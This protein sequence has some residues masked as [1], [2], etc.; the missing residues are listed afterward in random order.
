MIGW[1]VAIITG[2]AAVLAGY[3]WR[4]RLIAKLQK[5]L[6]Y[7]LP[8]FLLMN[9]RQII[10]GLIADPAVQKAV[11]EEAA[12]ADQP[13]STIE[14]R[15]IRY[16]KEIAPRFSVF[17]YF[18]IGYVLS[19]FLLK[20]HYAE[21]RA[22]FA[23]DL[24]SRL[25]PNATVV[26]VPNHRSNM[27]VLLLLYLASRTSVVIGGAGEWSRLWP[28]KALVHLAGGYVVD[29]RTGDALYRKVLARFIAQLTAAGVNQ[30]VFP[31]GGL[32]RDARPKESKLG[33]LHYVASAYSDSAERDIVFVPVGINY[34]R[35]PEDLRLV[36]DG[37]TAFSEH[38]KLFLVRA[39]VVYLREVCT[40][41]LN[42]GGYRYGLACADYG[43]PVSWQ[44]WVSWCGYDPGQLDAASHRRCLEELGRSL[45]ER[46]E[47]LIPVTPLTLLAR[48]CLDAPEHLASQKQLTDAF[49]VAA[50]TL[51]DKGQT[52]MF[53]AEEQ[54]KCLTGA[55]AIF[56]RLGVLVA[57][58]SGWK[59]A[60]PLSPLLK[61][62]ANA[63]SHL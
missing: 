15:A 53:S 2:G 4:R 37:G 36:R 42:R 59:V 30:L 54:P 11:A 47:E 1:L 7:G 32:S 9:R 51:R 3:L 20:L 6:P 13:V 61:Y 49:A 21:C 29:R 10:A 46:I 40:L 26:L 14:R 57:D 8:E 17:F 52:L 60:Q 5:E 50:A 25:D 12:S 28:F 39:T 34:D 58:D 55:I 43:H 22:R 41:I 23:P 35:V 45:M 33:I 56:T 31:E 48:L 62:Y 19:K 63:I 16:A 27:D 38:S 24:F 44:Q 18:R